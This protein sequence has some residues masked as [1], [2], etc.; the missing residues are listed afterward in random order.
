MNIIQQYYRLPINKV[1]RLILPFLAKTQ[2]QNGTTR[3]S[4]EVYCC[5]SEDINLKSTCTIILTHMQHCIQ[6]HLIA[7]VYHRL[8]F[9]RTALENS[10]L[11]RMLGSYNLT[12][13]TFVLPHQHRKARCRR[14][15]ARWDGFTRAVAANGAS[16]LQ[17]Q[18]ITELCHPLTLFFCLFTRTRYVEPGPPAGRGVH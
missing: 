10:F 7:L 5:M 6:G 14:H 9:S 4:L 1:H 13:D 15:S 3:C 8:L 2:S 12:D 16:E 17:Q 18:S 11:Y